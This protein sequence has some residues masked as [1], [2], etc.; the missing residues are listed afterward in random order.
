MA[1]F[2]D[3]KLKKKDKEDDERDE[4]IENY[5]HAYNFRFEE[6]NAGTITSHARNA[7][8]QESLRRKSET[9]KDA[10]QRKLTRKEEDKLRKKE[11]IS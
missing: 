1:D 2:E 5:E 6:P 10:R 9:R 8:A 3:P 11:E 4:E 7:L